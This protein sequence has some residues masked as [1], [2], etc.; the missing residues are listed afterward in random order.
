ML[1]DPVIASI[2]RVLGDPIQGGSGEWRFSTPFAGKSDRGYHLYVNSR[3]KK[4]FC[5]KS[6][7]AGSLSYLMYLLGAGGVETESQVQSLD[8]IEEN[9][10]AVDRV[11]TEI[12][13]AE[14]PEWYNPVWTGSTVHKYLN[15]RGI[16]DDDIGYYK[17]GEGSEDFAGWLIIPS[18]NKFGHC[19]YWVARRSWEEKWGGKYQNPSVHRRYHVGFL[20]LAIQNSPERIIVCEGSISALVAGRDATCAFG[21]FVT[22]IQI[23]R[24]H[25]SGVRH[26]V[27]AL[28]GDAF[29]ETL[30]TARRCLKIGLKVSIVLLPRD[31]DPAD[32]GRQ[33]FREKYLVNGVVEIGNELQ[34]MELEMYNIDQLARVKRRPPHETQGVSFTPQ[35]QR[36]PGRRS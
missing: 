16:T 29:K 31:R 30:D 13:I 1:Y 17:I 14:L 19:E 3:R 8:T 18:F 33:V 9:L 20:D 10:E 36:R 15:R 34:L 5:F 4:F 24:I 23:A 2:R 6:Q 28:D 26:V 25:R 21:K 12:P 11:D 27:L 7:Q 22:N 32:L 35:I